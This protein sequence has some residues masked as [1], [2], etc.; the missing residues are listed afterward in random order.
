MT[1]YV[2][3]DTQQPHGTTSR[4]GA[5]GPRFERPDGSRSW[6]AVLFLL[7][8]LAGWSIAIVAVA[9]VLTGL[10]A[11][12]LGF[13]VLACWLGAAII[14]WVIAARVIG[15]VWTGLAY[16]EAMARMRGEEGG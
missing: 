11:K 5:P 16:G 4:S 14:G 9:L 2:G 7:F 3:F 8:W 13:W 1:R 12:S 6:L 15:L 10:S